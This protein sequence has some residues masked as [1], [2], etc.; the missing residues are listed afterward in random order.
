MTKQNKQVDRDNISALVMAIAVLAVI[1]GFGVYFNS[2]DLN[3]ASSRQQ[4][5][6]VVSAAAL[7]HKLLSYLSGLVDQATFS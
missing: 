7:L 3:K 5:E 2:P 6:K 4:L 1:V